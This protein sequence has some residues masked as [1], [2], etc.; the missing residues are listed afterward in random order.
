MIMESSKDENDG[1]DSS[2]MMRINL[3][4]TSAPS[5]PRAEIS[6]SQINMTATKLRKSIADET[7]IPLSSLKLIFRGRLIADINEG[8]VITEYKLEDGCVIHCMGKPVIADASAS[9]TTSVN[10]ASLSAGASV[11][12]GGSA[13]TTTNNNSN[14]ESELLKDLG[15]LLNDLKSNC[16]SNEMYLTAV[17]TLEK[18][19]SN[20]TGQPMEEKYRKVKKENAAFQRRLGSIAGSG[21][22]L[23]AFGFKEQNVGGVPHYVLVPSPQAWPS[24]LKSHQQLKVAIQQAKANT[25]NNNNTNN[26]APLTNNN[27]NN[28]VPPA[29]SNFM[30]PPAPG[31][32]PPMMPGMESAMQNLMA[33]P[34]QL[35]SML[36]NPMVRSMME[37]DPRFANNPML[38]Q[39]LDALST[40][41]QMLEQMSTMMADPG[42]RSQINTMMGQQQSQQQPPS[43][44]STNTTT[45]TNANTNNTTGDRDLTE[46]EMIAEAIARSLREQ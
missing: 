19:I 38:R 26:S 23:K 39:S 28:I 25:N 24:L 43:M 8:D 37:N 11:S 20:I 14:R 40:N 31:N 5:S 33:N 17:T 4:L 12:M 1:G 45:T 42:M 16:S 2:N 10:N 36:Q 13:A 6:I 15:A 30:M 32:M 18:I 41:P 21:D 44:P 29:A 9:T 3:T 46:E 35:Q 22:I 34:Q 7:K 27:N